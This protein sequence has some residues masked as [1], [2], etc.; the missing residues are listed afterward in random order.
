MYKDIG[1]EVNA[2]LKEN[3]IETDAIKITIEVTP[4]KSKRRLTYMLEFDGTKE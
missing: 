1:T 3:A 4:L 2:F